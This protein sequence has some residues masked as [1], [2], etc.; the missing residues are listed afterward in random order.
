MS[1][2]ALDKYFTESFLD[3]K[4]RK[5]CDYTARIMSSQLFTCTDAFGFVF[6]TICGSFFGYTKLVVDKDANKFYDAYGKIYKD[7]VVQSISSAIDNIMRF[8][9]LMGYGYDV[10]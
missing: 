9:S 1:K 6:R 2:A 7:E 3:K 8:N 10:Y 5:A 4:L